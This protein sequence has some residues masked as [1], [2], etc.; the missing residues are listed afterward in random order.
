MRDSISVLSEQLKEA[1]INADVQV[2][3]WMS[4]S[5]N[6]PARHWQLERFDNEL[7]LAPSAGTATMEE[8]DLH[9][10]AHRQDPPMDAAF[11]RLYSPS[12]NRRGRSPG[13]TSKK[14]VLDQGYL[15]RS[16]IQVRC[17]ATT[18]GCRG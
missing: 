5:N 16:P 8:H 6:L 2:I 1:G 10:P 14:R 3:D 12:I 15:I 4:N 7:L 11:D 17:A 18:R 13:S 9:F